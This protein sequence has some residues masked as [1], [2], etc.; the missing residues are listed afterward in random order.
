MKLKW[1]N[2]A[3]YLVSHNDV[4]IIC[5]PWLSGDAFDHGWSLLSETKFQASDFA[6]VTHIWFS[7]EHPDHFSPPNL[8]L[9]IT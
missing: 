6:E 7:H 8:K 4:A 1:I 5:D 2:H 3:S 9:L